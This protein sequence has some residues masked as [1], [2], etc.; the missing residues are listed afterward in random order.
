MALPADVLVGNAALSCLVISDSH[1]GTTTFIAVQQL[2]QFIL[3]QLQVPPKHHTRVGQQVYSCVVQCSKGPDRFA[4]AAQLQ[5][6]IHKGAVHSGAGH[7]KLVSMDVAKQVCIKLHLSEA[8]IAGLSSP[9]CSGGLLCA[10]QYVPGHG[11]PSSGVGSSAGASTAVELPSSHAHN[12]EHSEVNTQPALQ[13]HMPDQL[14]SPNFSEQHLARSRCGLQTVHEAHGQMPAVNGQ[15]QVYKEWRLSPIQLS[16]PSWVHRMQPSSWPDHERELLRYLGFLFTVMHVQQPRLQH[17]LNGTLVVYYIAF[18]RAKGYSPKHMAQHVTSL[19]V[20]AEWVWQTQLTT[21]TKGPEQHELYSQLQLKLEALSKQCSSNLFPDPVKME[22][23]R[24]QVQQ[25]STMAAFQLVALMQALWNAA[26]SK[27][28][29]LQQGPLANR[30]AAAVYIMEVSMLCFFFGYLPPLRVSV[31]TSL[32]LPAAAHCNH[33]NCQHRDRCKGNRVNYIEGDDG[34]QKLQLYCPHHKSERFGKGPIDTVLPDEL[35]VLLHAHIQ[36]GRKL[37]ITSLRHR[38]IHAMAADSSFLFMWAETGK[39]VLPQQVSQLF[40]KVVLASTPDVSFGPQWCRSIFIGE[41]LGSGRLDVGM[42]DE[43]AASVMNNSVRVWEVAYDKYKASRQGA[44]VQQGMQQWRVGMLRQAQALDLHEAGATLLNQYASSEQQH[45]HGLQH[46]EPQLPLHH[47]QPQLQP[48]LEVELSSEEYVSDSDLESSSMSD[49]CMS[50]A[51]DDS[52][53][54]AS[55]EHLPTSSS[56]QL[57][58]ESAGVP[59]QQVLTAPKR[60][61]TNP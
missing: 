26:A 23:K 21:Q 54:G 5:H 17:V 34:N 27:V 46:Q 37:I 28:Q 43:A 49:A 15:L 61:F 52:S 44:E 31:V 9:P 20:A 18:L 53:S 3:Q 16:R 24:Q 10:R 42:S 6:L 57:S 12:L 22:R 39:P 51:S 36:T 35:Y 48:P 47:I 30:I 55:S 14:P 2:K 50:E 58:S 25:R 8:V 33:V 13:H 45:Q 1:R 4:N 11:A 40:R 60:F 32:L 59:H 29:L 7:V 38:G 56:E 19:R 41:R